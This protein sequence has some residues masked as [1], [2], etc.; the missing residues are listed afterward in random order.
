MSRSNPAT[1]YLDLANKLFENVVSER[2]LSAITSRLPP[3]SEDILHK[4]AHHAEEAGLLEPRRGWTIA[5]IGD[6]AANSQKRDLI[7]RSMAA[8]Y[9]G[10]TCN[11]WTR[12][13]RV[14]AAI[15][16]AREG[17]IKLNQPGWVAACDWQLN[18]LSWTKPDFKQATWELKQA[19]EDMQKANFY[20]FIPQCRLSLAFALILI[21]KFDEAHENILAS[22]ATFSAQKDTLNQARC[23]RIEAGR[24]RRMARFDEAIDLLRKANEVFVDKNAFL[25]VA[26][27]HNQLGLIHM[28]RTDDLAVAL[29]HFE[30]AAQ[31]YA[32]AD[33]DLWQAACKTSIGAIYSQYGDFSKAE[34]SYR[35]ARASFIRHDVLGLLADNLNDSGKLNTLRGFPRIAVEEFKRAEELDEKLGSSL[36][37]AIQMINLGEVYGQIGRYQDALHHL[38][39]AAD[40]LKQFNNPLLMGTCENYTALIWWR[41]GQLSLAHEHL[42]KA[43]I[44]YQEA[45]QTAYLSLVQNFR[46]SLFVEQGAL[47]KAIECLKD[48]LQIAEAHGIRP[49]AAL[50]RRLLGEAY[51]RTGQYE[52][53]QNY[54]ERA[55]RDFTE[56]EMAMERAATLVSLGVYYTQTSAIDKARSAFKAALQA[57]KNSFPEVDWRAHTGQACL[58]EKHGEITTALREY[59]WGEEALSKVRSNF[60]Q[61]A[62][63]GSY[64]QSPSLFYDKAVLLAIKA[65]NSHDVI[66]F[67]ENNK[68]TTLLHLITASRIPTEDKKSQELNDLRAEINWLQEQL[69]VSYD[70]SNPIMSSRRSRQLHTHLVDKI[71]Q[72]DSLMARLERQ[73]SSDHTATILPQVF[74][75]SVFREL[76][77]RSAGKS[78]V[79][80]D[81]YL[82]ED[83]LVVGVVTPDSCQSQSAVLSPRIKIAL[84]ESLKARRNMTSLSKSDLKVLG[85]FFIPHSVAEI[86]T[87]D[88]C[89]LLAPHRTLHGL[90]WGALQHGSFSQPLACVCTPNIIPS[91]HSLVLLLE[92]HLSNPA[93]T[94]D[95]GLVIGLSEFRGAYQELPFVKSEIDAIQAKMGPSTKVLRENEASWENVQGLVASGGSRNP[96]GLSCFTWLHIASHVLS[97]VHTGRLSGIALWDGDIWLDQLLDLAPLPRM[98]T[99]SAC[100]SIYSVIYQGDEHVGLPT[101]CM[102]AGAQSIVGSIRPI[103]D[104]LATEFMID[105][106]GHYLDGLRPSQA[107]VH[108]QRQ[109]IERGVD[110]ASWASFVSVGV[111]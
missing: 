32:Q 96:G 104:R 60:W 66:H 40:R 15:G 63:A 76:I 81:F 20:D 6:S 53:A 55:L 85:D 69:R 102:T 42:D 48:S 46:A 4:L 105:F 92:R 7:V 58:A 71:K 99:F 47:E 50:A 107:V 39:R 93:S 62:L 44:H 86:L 82:T 98:V 31:I 94:R 35:E 80:L 43:T 22:E 108:A 72:Y 8:W 91:L 23:W 2:D 49:H 70:R 17:F 103:P 52:D 12:P 26:S 1:A 56:M 33:L 73:G 79:A 100:N 9:L 19:L 109:M 38:E 101:T 29:S 61:P 25:D 57:S 11:Q 34:E 51:L 67:I 21:G 74:D 14:V 77:E 68:A 110:A 45:K 37:A 84:D 13:K 10:R 24:L 5:A 90:P 65:D 111:P 106:Y 41:L 16:R 83:Q 36:S 28:L 64:L 3:L 54:L 89:L 88:T 27:V 75:L 59:R 97:D 87:P 18:A 78:W 95:H 30:Q